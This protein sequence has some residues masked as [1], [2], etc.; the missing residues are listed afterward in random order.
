MNTLE[1]LMGMDYEKL[2]EVP[3]KQIEIK[4]LSDIAGQPFIVT[5][6]AIPGRR[7]MALSGSS[8]DKNGALNYEKAYDANI[9]IVL[10]GVVDPEL[11]NEDLQK[12]FGAPTPAV[13]VERI[14]KGGEIA[15]LSDE[16]SHLS[17]FQNNAEDDIKN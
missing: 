8:Y 6:Q 5:I 10:A 12:A 7:M 17:G 1:L 16:I 13:L 4:R 15:M 2:T 3:Q 11:K 14:F 9:R